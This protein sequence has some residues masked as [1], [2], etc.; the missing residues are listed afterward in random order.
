MSC[1]EHQ[2]LLQDESNSWA[3]WKSLTDSGSQNDKELTRLWNNAADASTRLRLH[4][5]SC[6]ECQPNKVVL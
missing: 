4:L 2:R 1:L 6:P 3:A 5:M